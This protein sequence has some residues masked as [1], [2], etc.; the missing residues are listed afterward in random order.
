[1]KILDLKKPAAVAVIIFATNSLCGAAELKAYYSKSAVQPVV[2]QPLQD[3]EISIRYHVLPESAFYSAGVDY[4]KVGETL[5]ISVVRSAVDTRAVPMART[6]LPLDGR[7]EAE[8][9][10]PYHGEKVV[11]ISTDSEDQIYP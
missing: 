9:H 11:L 10:I 4:E 5:K 2:A 6:V 7:W 1:M 8:V 3:N